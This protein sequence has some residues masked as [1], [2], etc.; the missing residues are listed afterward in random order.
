[1]R[2]HELERMIR[3]LKDP[4][5]PWDHKLER[6]I[7]DPKDP[8]LPLEITSWKVGSFP[9]CDLSFLIN[10]LESNL[11]IK[12]NSSRNFFSFFSYNSSYYIKGMEI[13]W[14]TIEIYDGLNLILV[15]FIWKIKA[16]EFEPRCSWIQMLLCLLPSY[17]ISFFSIGQLI[18]LLNL[19]AWIDLDKTFIS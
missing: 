18:P 6:W 2:N 8:F 9:I 1:M 12:Y 15:W 13:K 10:H 14:R 19:F 7:R 5:L 16:H 3:D 11:V 17:S 4:F